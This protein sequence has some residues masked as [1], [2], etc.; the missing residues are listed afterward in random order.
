MGSSCDHSII[1]TYAITLLLPLWGRLAKIRVLIHSSSFGVK[2]CYR[3]V[4]TNCVLGAD[5]HSHVVYPHSH[6]VDPYR[7]QWMF[8]PHMSK[9]S[10]PV[11]K[12][13]CNQG[14]PSAAAAAEI[15]SI[16]IPSLCFARILPALCETRS[17][18]W[19]RLPRGPHSSPQPH[20]STH[21][22]SH[23]TACCKVHF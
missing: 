16:Q 14:D 7:D 10:L 12:G 18:T 17:V 21:C 3:S 6:V 22:Q 5:P 1:Y 4:P 9:L 15:E 2:T 23:I 19:G 13:A 8:D 20:M 11:W